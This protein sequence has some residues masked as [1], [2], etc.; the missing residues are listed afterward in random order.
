MTEELFIKKNKEHW[1][2]LESYNEILKRKKISTFSKEELRDFAQ[3]LR[4]TSRNLSYA[5]THFSNGKASMYLNRIAG[6][7]HQHFFLKRKSN[8]QD[9]SDYFLKGF[10]SGVRKIQMHFFASAAIFLLGTLV[11]MVM[12]LLNREYFSLF[13]PEAYSQAL[14]P[15]S[16]GAGAT[17]ASLYPLISAY[18]MTNNIRVCFSAFAL[19]ITAGIGTLCIL[20]LNGAVIGALSGYMLSMNYG[21]LEFFSLIL[22]H[23]IIEL[24]AIYICGACGLIIGHSI[25][26]PKDLKRKDAL[27]KGAKEAAY[28]MPGIIAMLVVAGLI[29]GFFTPL[30]ISAW[31]K[32]AFAATSA[33]LAVA[34][35]K[36][37][38][39]NHIR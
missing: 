18:V 9:L 16:G 11:S 35:F 26:I 39:K 1:E 30:D 31:L 36:L 2:R 34:Y 8:F 38:G 24:A 20:F 32:I 5:Q 14:E 29:E 3:E 22:P 23:G 6:I 27:I 4:R 10:P 33:V 12:I 17:S 19:G 37:A 25:L 7:S 28:F 21:M 13:L 15:S